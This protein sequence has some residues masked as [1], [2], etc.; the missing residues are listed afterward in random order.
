LVCQKRFIERVQQHELGAE[1][2][3]EGRC[4]THDVAPDRAVIHRGK[5]PPG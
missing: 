2:L 3:G 4:P 1:V 5:N